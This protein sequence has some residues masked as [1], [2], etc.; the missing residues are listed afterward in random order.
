MK[1]TQQTKCHLQSKITTTYWKMT[2]S[3]TTTMMM[4]MI[5]GEEHNKKLQMRM[6][7]MDD[8][9]CH[10]GISTVSTD[11]LVKIRL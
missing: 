8:I 9:S 10:A 2:W 3:N 5:I 4:M 1:S 11:I 7:M 6:D